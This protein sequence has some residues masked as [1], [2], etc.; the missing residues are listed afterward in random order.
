V[1]RTPDAGRDLSGAGIQER[2]GEQRL[3]GVLRFGGELVVVIE[4]KV[5]GEASSDQAALLR[6]RGV[7]VGHSRVVW[8]GWHE[9]LE[10]WCLPMLGGLCAVPGGEPAQ[11]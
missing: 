11:P 9:M 4:R 1:A 10:D 6:L 7:G 3:D 2:P 5:V 8:L